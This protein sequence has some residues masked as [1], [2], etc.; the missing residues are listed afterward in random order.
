MEPTYPLD[1]RIC[2]ACL[3]V[4]LPAHLAAHEVFTPDY[5]YHSSVSSSWVEHARRYAETMTARFGLGPDSLV[6]EVASNDGYLLQHLLAAG[7]GVLGVEPA[8]EVAEVARSRG[9]PTEVCFLGEQSARRIRAEHG[10]ADLV[11]ANNVFA[12]VPDVADFSRGLRRLVADDGFLTL[13]FPH[14]LQLI[15]ERQFDT[16]YH[17]HYQYWTLATATA[18]LARAD[19]QVV[20]VEELGTHGGSLRLHVRP[21]S[22]HPVTDRVGAVLAAEAAAGL[23]CLDGYRGFA[24]QVAAVKRDLLDLLIALA[25]SG[26]SIAGYGAPGKGNTLLNHCGIRTDLLPFT[27]DRNP[28]KHGRWCPGSRIPVRPV[29]VLADDPPDF[30]L[31]LPWNL[32]EEISAQLAPLRARGTRLVTAIPELRVDG[33]PVGD[34]RRLLGASR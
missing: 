14:L 7:I 31:V 15:A 1:V 6:V 33:V 24:D 22:G 16:I 10:P 29:E 4:Q 2:D 3:L 18:A 12:H 13:E 9:V 32:I 11:V 17:E 25:R 23:H 20:D 8:R 28:V 27:V 21:G 26:R 19:L 5:A 34:V 30:L